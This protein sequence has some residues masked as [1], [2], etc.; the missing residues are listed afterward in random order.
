MHRS[1]RRLGREGLL[2]KAM[3]RKAEAFENI[4]RPILK[5]H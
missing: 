4:D 3:A 1:E 5:R 2:S